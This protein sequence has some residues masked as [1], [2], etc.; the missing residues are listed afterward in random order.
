MSYFRQ[1]FDVASSTYTYCL[2]DLVSCEAVLI[3][4]VLEH[5]GLYQS[6]VEELGLQLKLVLETHVHADHITASSDLRK[7]T[8]AK[9]GVSAAA[10]LS[11]ADYQL[12][13]GQTLQFGEESITCLATP[14]HTVGCMSYRWRDK[15]FTGDALLIGGCGRTDF[16][17]GDA[18]V[19]YDSITQNIWPLADEVLVYPGHDYHHRHV[20]NVIQERETN[21]RL[22]GRTRDEFIALMGA[23]DLPKPA[24]IQRAVPANRLC[25]SPEVVYAN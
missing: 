14:G 16:Q 11:C 25:G 8:G 7:L 19:L 2:A 3:D 4:P 6:L 21:Q 5:T 20:S 12:T 24:A 13:H 22:A 17:G 18:G 23:L 15:I 1:L 10:E 9:I